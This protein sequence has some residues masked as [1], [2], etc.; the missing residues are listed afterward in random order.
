VAG[1]STAERKCLHRK[2]RVRTFILHQLLERHAERDEH[3]AALLELAD[4]V[5]ITSFRLPIAMGRV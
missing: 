1:H 3:A 4:K 5:R 2:I